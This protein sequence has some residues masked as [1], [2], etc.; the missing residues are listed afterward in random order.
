[1]AKILVLF[2]PQA[3]EI[4][5]TVRNNHPDFSAKNKGMDLTQLLKVLLESR[6]YEQLRADTNSERIKKMCVVD[7]KQEKAVGC[8]LTIG[9]DVINEIKAKKLMVKR[10]VMLLFDEGIEGI[11]TDVKVETAGKLKTFI[12]KYVWETGNAL[13]KQHNKT[14]S[15]ALAL[16]YQAAVSAPEAVNTKLIERISF[17]GKNTSFAGITMPQNI[18]AE[19]LKEL[20]KKYK[21]NKSWVVML[22]L[23]HFERLMER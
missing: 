21:L 12:Y 9:D 15:A 8:P 7:Q 14:F 3:R 20:G 22:I 18:T 13:A 6:P 16:G 19:M 23:K 17:E 1:M 11:Q 4:I 2:H 5:E 10:L